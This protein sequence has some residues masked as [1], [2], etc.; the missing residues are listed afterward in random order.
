[1]SSTDNDPVPPDEGASAAPSSALAENA[2]A[3]AV[4]PKRRRVPRRPAAADNNEMASGADSP[5]APVAPAE[6]GAAAPAESPADAPTG[7]GP[8][9][10]DGTSGA[11]DGPRSRRNRNRRRGRRG[12]ERRGEGA[13]AEQPPVNSPAMAEAAAA[14]APQA[15]ELFGALISGAFDTEPSIDAPPSEATAAEAVAQTPPVQAVD[16]DIENPETIHADNAQPDT[17]PPAADRRVLAPDADAPKLHKVLAQS[18]VGSRR[19]LEEMIAGGRVAV[20]GEPAHTGQRISFGDRI[21]IDGKPVRYRIAPPPPRVLAYHKPAG[22]VVTH[23]DPQARPTVFRRLPRLQQGKWQSV[24]RL[25]I[26]T[27]GLLLFTN[28]GELANQLMHP[29]FGVEREYAV[30]SLGELAA[31]AKVRLLEGVEIDGQR[32]AFKSIEDGGGEGANHWY[33]C[34][35]TEGRNREVRRLF[36]SCGHAVSRLIRIRY[37]SVVLPRGLKRGV[38]VDLG[39]G[40]LRALRRLTGMPQRAERGPGDE[41][42]ETREPRGARPPRE[43]RPGDREGRDGRGKRNNNRRGGG[44]G[45]GG[46]GRG[47]EGANGAPAFVGDPPPPRAERDPRDQPDPREPRD[48][49]LPRQPQERGDPGLIPNPLQQTFDK[50]AI[51]QAR[52]QE[53]EISDDAPIPNP[54]QQTYD[55]RALQRDRAAPREISDDAPIPN[56]LQQTFDRRFANGNGGGGGGG[57]AGRPGKGGGG[58]GAGA[59][60]NGAR[61]R[62]KRPNAGAGDPN[63][64]PDPMQTSVGFIGAD[65]FHRKGGNRGGTKRRSGGAGPG[66]G[67][68]VGQGPKGGNRGG[69]GGGGGGNRGGGQGGRGGPTR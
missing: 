62:G 25:D 3:V 33:R 54:L 31:E 20:N 30:R 56:P 1:M 36:E 16:I 18:G 51:Q 40:D 57:G 29:R 34:V 35:I 5:A 52:A 14:A 2:G 63:R 67:S 41:A 11:E 42:S 32:C 47:R 39:D 37:G 48:P 69:G 27:E 46:G 65:A 8:P 6:L 50:R 17:G 10:A 64:Q 61:G 22:E 45:G 49:R 60:R 7:G 68:F 44:G 23:D 28:S 43:P 15:N 55:K 24:G 59:G 9:A 38:W 66:G 21:T 58:G 53:R 12:G 19:D 13:V 26:N 4:K